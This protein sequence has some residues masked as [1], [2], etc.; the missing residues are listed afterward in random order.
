M[1]HDE[2]P[3]K[4]ERAFVKVVT[5]RADLRGDGKAEFAAKLWPWMNP[6]IAATRWSAI[7]EK[8][9]HTGKPQNVTI[10]D[11]QRMA[12][13]LGEELSYLAVLA[14]EEVFKDLQEAKVKGAKA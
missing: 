7:R 1:K 3:K 5:Q 4:I 14:K 2:Y 11:A 9:A 12:D 10:A 6:K 13:A 8:A